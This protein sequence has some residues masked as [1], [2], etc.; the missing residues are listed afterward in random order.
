MDFA[1]FVF[2]AVLI[3]RLIEYFIKPRVDGKF[4]IYVA[5]VLAELVSFGYKLDL[6]SSLGI[7]TAN[8]IGIALTGLVLAGG[9]NFLNDII[10]AVRSQKTEAAS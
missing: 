7:G 6:I 1:A 3:E 8:W 9:S 2:F 4:I 5:I 10:G